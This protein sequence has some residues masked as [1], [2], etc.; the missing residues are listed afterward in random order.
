MP[1]NL[2]LGLQEQLIIVFKKIS[3]YFT[4]FVLQILKEEKK[5]LRPNH[6]NNKIIWEVY[7]RMCTQ[8]GTSHITAPMNSLMAYIQ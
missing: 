7:L 1:H 8:K 3:K 5:K 6:E 2:W 4:Y